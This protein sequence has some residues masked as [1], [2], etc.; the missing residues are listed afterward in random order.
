M[1]SSDDTPPPPVASTAAA[2]AAAA[3]SDNDDDDETMARKLEAFEQ[4]TTVY[5]FGPEAASEALNIMGPHDISACCSFILDSG[6]G[7]DQGG[8][9][10]PKEDCPH[11]QH[12]VKLLS[13]AWWSQ[14]LLEDDDNDNSFDP[15]NTTCSHFQDTK[16]TTTVTTTATA[17]AGETGASGSAKVEIDNETGV[18][19]SKENWLCLECGVLRCSRYVNGHGLKHW[20]M[21][22]ANAIATTEDPITKVGH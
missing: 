14:L 12:H 7:F 4:L 5:G 16:T 6:L 10:I 19:S 2:A 18:C 15:T 1:S 21:T 20:E 17:A 9:V 11:V 22:K 8:P 13:T 3:A